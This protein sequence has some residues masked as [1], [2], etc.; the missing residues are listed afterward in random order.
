MTKPKTD[1]EDAAYREGHSQG[2]AEQVA[3]TVAVQR[4]YED[5]TAA[6][7]I[8]SGQRDRLSDALGQALAD[9]QVYCQERDEWKAR[10]LDAEGRIA[11]A[12]T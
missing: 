5:A 6:W 10:A 3:N 9:A 7:G 12:L 2:V 4:R 11:D 8:V 1:A